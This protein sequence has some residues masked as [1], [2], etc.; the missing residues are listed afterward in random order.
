MTRLVKFSVMLGAAGLAFISLQ[1]ASAAPVEKSGGTY[2]KRV[3]PKTTGDQV[4]RCHSLVVTDSKGH[5]IETPASPPPPKQAEPPK[6]D[7]SS[8]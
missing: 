5:P 2:F 7:R 3:C 1:A 8:H 4:V 6:S